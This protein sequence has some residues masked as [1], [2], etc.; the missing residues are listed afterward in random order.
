MAALAIKAPSPATRTHELSGGNQQKVAIGKWLEVAPRVFLL[1]DPTRGVDVGAKAEI[2]EIVRR[3]AEAGGIVLF[4]S[5]DLAELAGLSDRILV[6]Y[7]G[8]LSAELAGRDATA[9][10][11]SLL[12]N[13][14]HGAKPPVRQEEPA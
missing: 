13:A 2:Y 12:I 4:R 1:D 6:F 5:T 11:L 7:R 8:R 14:G 3:M 10:R 9:Q